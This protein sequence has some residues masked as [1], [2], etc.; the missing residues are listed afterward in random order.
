[1][2]YLTRSILI[3]CMIIATFLLPVAHLLQ[4]KNGTTTVFLKNIE[5]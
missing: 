4:F 2:I 5:S 1:M 3:C